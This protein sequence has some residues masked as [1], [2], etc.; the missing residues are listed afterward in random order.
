M[1]TGR[2]LI[3]VLCAA[4][5]LF[6][7]VAA[8]AEPI[9]TP[10]LMDANGLC[11]KPRTPSGVVALARPLTVILRILI[12]PDGVPIRTEIVQS[13]GS[14]AFDESVSN[15]FLKCP[16]IGAKIDG[17]PDPEPAWAQIKYWYRPSDQR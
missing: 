17:E 7:T 15:G 2:A 9:R 6:S 12:G 11:R 4:T 8:M 16:Y 3:Q 14:D 13:S 10:P 5:A 1:R